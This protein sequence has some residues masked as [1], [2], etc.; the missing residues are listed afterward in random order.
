MNLAWMAALAVIFLVEKNWQHGVA[1][2]KVVGIGTVAL[3]VAVIVHP[4]LLSSIASTAM[5]TPMPMSP[6]MSM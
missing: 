5:A 6:S 2:T 3:G 4:Q 1:L